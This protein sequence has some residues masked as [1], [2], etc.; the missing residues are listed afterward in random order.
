MRQRPVACL[1][2]HRSRSTPPHWIQLA[3]V[4]SS[5]SGKSDHTLSADLPFGAKTALSTSKLGDVRNAWRAGG[6]G[7]VPVCNQSGAGVFFRLFIARPMISS[8][9]STLEIAE[10]CSA[11]AIS[12][13]SLGSV[14]Q[15]TPVHSVTVLSSPTDGSGLRATRDR[16]LLSLG[17]GLAGHADVSSREARDVVPQTFA[18][19]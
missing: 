13:F 6:A 18:S 17:G 14:L 12:R 11:V 19:N 7:A 8:I 5:S 2:R 10:R 4:F 3:G 15:L 16:R 9:L 1:W